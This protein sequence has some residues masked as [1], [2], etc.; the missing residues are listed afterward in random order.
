[1]DR[2]VR[3]RLFGRHDDLLEQYAMANGLEDVITQHGMVGRDESLRRQRESQILFYPDWED[4]AQTGISSLKVMEYLA[5]GRPI[6]MTGGFQGAMTSKIVEETNTGR[7]AR[8]L[9]EV[10]SILVIYFKEY[11]AQG[12]VSYHGLQE[13]ISKYD[14]KVISKRYLALLK[15]KA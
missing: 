8:S 5:S 6:L 14:F 1:M 3:F 9:E 13:E 4:R 15:E 7:V 2:S 10:K 12:I 11:S